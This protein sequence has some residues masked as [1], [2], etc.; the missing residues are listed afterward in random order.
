[1]KRELTELSK[2]VLRPQYIIT[3]MW[4][5][6]QRRRL[7][8]V[9]VCCDTHLWFP[10]PKLYYCAYYIQRPFV[11]LTAGFPRG[12]SLIDPNTFRPASYTYGFFA[13]ASAQRLWNVM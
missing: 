7:V 3:V 8:S 9:R 5:M 6:G 13:S 10:T 11:R 1:M 2:L 12:G 4:P